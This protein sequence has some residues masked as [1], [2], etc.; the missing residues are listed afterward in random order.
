MA[1]ST[2]RPPVVVRTFTAEEILRGIEKLHRRIKEVESLR[3]NVAFS[4]AR[5]R[6]VEANIR[7]TIRNVFGPQSPELDDHEH[8]EIGHGPGSVSHRGQDMQA[9][10]LAGIPQTAQMLQ[11]LIDRLSER[12]EDTPARSAPRRASNLKPRPWAPVER[13]SSSTATITARRRP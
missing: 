4:D 12:L 3:E 13:C 11:G 1:K 8:H 7:E 6:T 5:V 10:F 2:E 9:R